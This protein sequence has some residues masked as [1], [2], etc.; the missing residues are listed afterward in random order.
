[1]RKYS[2]IY[3]EIVEKTRIFTII[4]VLMSTIKHEKI[5]KMYKCLKSNT[6]L[7]SDDMTVLL[8]IQK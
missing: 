1:M 5:N 8:E 6:L 4:K 2:I 3:L 7:F